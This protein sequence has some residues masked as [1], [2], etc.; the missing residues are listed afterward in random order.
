V[1]GSDS[2]AGA[3]RRVRLA[4]RRARDERGF[5]QGQVAEAMEW[6]LSKVMR[7]ESGD[8]TIS[9]NDL[10]PLLAHLG[11]TDRAG[12]EALIQD[13]RLARRRQMWWDE[14]KFRQHLTPNMRQQIQY[15]AEAIACH[16]F[17]S[18]VI[19]G[20]LQTREYAQ[21]TLDGFADVLSA[22]EIG[23]R[24][25]ARM[26][27]RADFLNRREP[28]EVCVL[29][30]ESVTRRRIADDRI[31]ADQLL[32][33][34]ELARQ[35]RLD[36]RIW[37]FAQ[38][39][40]PMMLGPFELLTLPGGDDVMYRESMLLDEIVEDRANVGRHRISFDKQ[41]QAALDAPA[42]FV[43]LEACAKDLLRGAN[44]PGAT[45]GAIEVSE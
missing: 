45:P 40:P 3:R 38:P 36:V 25:Q 20:M 29:L 17:A 31:T 37:P 19:P 21:A 18:V 4:L 13:A 14:P 35:G 32:D 6:S 2:P 44:D 28:P 8:V 10:R 22:D 1:G 27:R 26:R 5:T 24:V 33:L 39:G 11:I 42:S 9:P 41:W 7:I 12:V 43:M 16:L 23:T 30:D 15:E 34:L